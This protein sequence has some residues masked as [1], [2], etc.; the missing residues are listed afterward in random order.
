MYI[1]IYTHESAVPLRAESQAPPTHWIS[2]DVNE[3]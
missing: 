2:K 1:Y 3:P